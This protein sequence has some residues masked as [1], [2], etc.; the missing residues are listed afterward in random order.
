MQYKAFLSPRPDQ[1]PPDVVPAETNGVALVWV[2][3]QPQQFALDVR[4]GEA[5]PCILVISVCEIPECCCRANL[6]SP[7]APLLV[8]T[9]TESPSR[10]HKHRHC[11]GAWGIGNGGGDTCLDGSG[12]QDVCGGVDDTHD[13]FDTCVPTE[14]GE[15]DDLCNPGEYKGSEDSCFD[16]LPSSDK[17]EGIKDDVDEC[18]GGSSDVDDC[19]PMITGS[20]ELCEKDSCDSNDDCKAGDACDLNDECGVADTCG[21]DDGCK[22][23][24][25]CPSGGLGGD[26][27]GSETFEALT[28]SVSKMIMRNRR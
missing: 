15:P 8:H 4:T 2:S 12:S 16:G 9:N 23:N 13:E 10:Q 17:C 22:S 19:D 18:P 1:V 28:I 6:Q 27:C 14:D 5:I 24:D 11:N 21:S 20:D 3:T 26:S 25:S 7:Q